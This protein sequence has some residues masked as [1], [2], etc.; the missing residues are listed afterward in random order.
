VIAA[1][2]AFVVTVLFMFALRPLAIAVG[3]IDI[4]GGRKRH[5]VAV[6]V[7]GGIAMSIGLGL[8]S[9]LVSHPDSW[10]PILLG[11]YLLAVV[12][13]IDDRFDLPANVRLIAQSCA[14][15][16]VAIASGVVV[17]QLGEF[18]GHTLSLGPIRA[19]H[20]CVRA[21]L[22]E[23]FNFIDGIG[24]LRRLGTSLLDGPGCASFRHPSF[25]LVT[26]AASVV[27]GF[28][29]FNLP[30]GVNGPVRSF[31]GDAGST[32]LGLIIATMGI[33]LTQGETRVISP[34]A[35]LW[36]VAVPVFEL[37]ST[38]LRRLLSKR[39]PFAPDH[40]HLHHVLADNGPSRRAT[41]ILIL[42]LAALFAVVG[43]LGDAL[44]VSDSVMLAPASGGAAYYQLLRYPRAVV[45]A[46]R[47][48]QRPAA[49]QVAWRPWLRAR[50]DFEP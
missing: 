42:G 27:A 2:L 31:M 46:A 23:R 18:F 47:W 29:L 9:S 36:F 13:T 10:S 50:S 15:L 22:V 7:I 11:V 30:L 21:H 45:A 33:Y 4:P 44:A 1:F 12:G 38:I 24:A 25:P 41:L 16:L 20:D 49:A 35:A 40:E 43:L 32:A 8:G 39:S 34:A 19:V 26:V 3:L 48:L 28:L 5:G 14:A 17:S 37:F 6:P